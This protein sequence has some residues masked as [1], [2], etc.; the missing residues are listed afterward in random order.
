VGGRAAQATRSQVLQ[1]D[2][3]AAF[4]PQLSLSD[5]WYL[6]CSVRGSSGA[7]S[8]AGPE[9][10]RCL[11]TSAGRRLQLQPC[12]AQACAAGRAQAKGEANFWTATP[13]GR[14]REGGPTTGRPSQAPKF[15]GSILS[16]S[17]STVSL[18]LDGSVLTSG[19]VQGT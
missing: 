16:L 14:R 10:W 3:H 1:E 17:R 4:G 18:L 8:G 11:C 15:D 5:P 9:P 19:M 2:T 6:Q 12:R 13:G 7:S